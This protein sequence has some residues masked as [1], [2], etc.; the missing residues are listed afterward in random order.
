MNTNASAPPLSLSVAPASDTALAFQHLHHS[1]IPYGHVLLLEMNWVRQTRRTSVTI[2]ARGG[3]GFRA[4]APLP[5][6]LQRSEMRFYDYI[7]LNLSA[8]RPRIKGCLTRMRIAKLRFLKVGP[9]APVHQINAYSVEQRSRRTL[10]AGFQRLELLLAPLWL[11]MLL[12][13]RTTAA[14]RRLRNCG[15]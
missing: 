6:G 10:N 3:N 9:C 2:L 14:Y 8:R 7:A 4:Q 12:R 11:A 1:G 15:N 5:S 13:P